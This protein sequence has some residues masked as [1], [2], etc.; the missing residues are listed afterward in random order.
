GRLDFQDKQGIGNTIPKYTFGISPSM[1]YKGFDLNILSQGILG[2]DVYTQNN[3]T[4]LD[5][6]NRVI[7]TRWLK[8]WTPDNPSTRI[9][10]AKFDNSWDESQSSY[11]VQELNYIKLKNIQLGYAIPESLLLRTK[12]EKAYI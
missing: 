4:N 1:K 8:S 10:S 3:F 2:V 7:S 12:L 6:E 11:W 9:P 5:Y